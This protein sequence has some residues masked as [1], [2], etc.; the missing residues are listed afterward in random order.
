MLA[1]IFNAVAEKEEDEE[2]GEDDDI[3]DEDIEENSTRIRSRRK[4]KRKEKSLEMRILE[5]HLLMPLIS[6]ISNKKVKNTEVR[7]QTVR[8]IAGLAGVCA[9]YVTAKHDITLKIQGLIRGWPLAL[10]ELT[11]CLES[12]NILVQTDA[13]RALAALAKM[14][15]LQDAIVSSRTWCSRISLFLFTYSEDSLVSPTHNTRIPINRAFSLFLGYA[16]DRHDARTQ[17]LWI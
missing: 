16:I 1:N 13:A 5:S 11:K 15:S 8:A 2:D 10:P 12:P 3:D 7:H 9:N 6:L 17:V 4:R 14:T